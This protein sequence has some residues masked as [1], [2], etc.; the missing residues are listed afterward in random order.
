MRMLIVDD[1]PL[2]RMGVR[3]AFAETGDWEG[4][5]EAGSLAEAE[6]A[7]AG[8]GLDLVLLD[9]SLPD[10]NGFELLERHA[11]AVGRP[12]FLVLSMNADRGVARRALGL[13]AAGYASKGIKLESL[14]LA[15]RLVAAGEL[16]IESEIL[17]DLITAPFPP[18]EV[19]PAALSRIESL[20]P[21][22][23][24]ALA[25]LLEGLSTKE[26]AARLGVSQRTAEN[27]QSSLYSKLDCEGP[28]ALVRL[29]CRAGVF[30]PSA[31]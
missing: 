25:A 19:D 3:N 30:E 16:Y 14:M 24:T 13:G 4:I 8:G 18:A 28:I 17:R 9:L 11:R 6:T 5:R 1:H 22:E 7:L 31:T 20:S 12:A 10:G 29:A 21:R 27:Y 23:K 15:A 2:F 26:I